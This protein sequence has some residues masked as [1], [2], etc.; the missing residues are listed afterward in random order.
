MLQ[1][2]TNVLTMHENCE[3][4]FRRNFMKRHS[5]IHDSLK[6]DMSWDGWGQIPE[7]Y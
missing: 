4:S 7:V 5:I 2:N 3:G 6:I 1:K